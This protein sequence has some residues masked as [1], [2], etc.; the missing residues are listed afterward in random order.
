MLENERGIAEE[1][2]NESKARNSLF[3]VVCISDTELLARVA[4]DLMPAFDNVLLVEPQFE[5]NLIT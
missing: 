2:E 4:C 1:V 3:R 5:I